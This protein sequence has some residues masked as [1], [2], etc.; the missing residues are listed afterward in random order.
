MKINERTI[1]G[2]KTETKERWISTPT[3]DNP[4][5]GHMETYEEQIPIT[6]VVTREATEEELAELNKPIPKEVEIEQIRKALYDTDY[7]WGKWLEQTALGLPLEYT[8]E[9]IHAEKQALRDRLNEL[10]ESL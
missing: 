7:K 8:I 3:E 5:G 6:E 4:N 10:E 9:E 1:V 2:Y